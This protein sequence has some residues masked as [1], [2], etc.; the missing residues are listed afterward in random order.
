V[1]AR[2]VLFGATGYTGRLLA[3]ALVERGARPLLAARGADRLTD[4]GAELGGLETAVADVGRPETVRAL[5]GP[6][7]VLVSTVGPFVRF[8]GP[9]VDAA[10]EA[11]ATYLDSTGEPQFIRH[12]FEDC[13]PRAEAAGC[14]L[15]TAFGYDWVPGNLTWP[16]R[17]PC[18]TRASAPRASRSATTSPARRPAA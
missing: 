13:G 7:D 16:A 10:I 17:S 18:A 9:A 3:E 6:G 8:G 15:V 11:G 5:V 2:I 4:L 14:A 12:V 1:A